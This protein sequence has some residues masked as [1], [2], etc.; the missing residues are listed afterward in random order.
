[1]KSLSLIAIPLMLAGAAAVPDTVVIDS[2]TQ[3]ALRLALDDERKSEAIY[4]AVLEVH[5]G[6][7]P[8]D[9]VVQAERRHQQW[10]LD[11]FDRYEL[12]IP[13]NRWAAQP[14]QA[15]E[16]LLAACQQ[17]VTAEID[18][19]ALYDR[20]FEFVKEP[21]I[22]QV[23]T[24]LRDASQERHLRAFNRCVDRGGVMGMGMGHGKGRGMGRG[25]GP[26]GGSG[27]GGGGCCGGCGACG[28][29]GPGAESPGR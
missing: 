16:T 4:Q 10:L 19:V 27:C 26:G 17:A 12:E 11:L 22:R 2:Q 1:M 13:E 7:L 5:P 15:P 6:A 29:P 14:P 24:T 23:F 18:N 3:E 8:F 20:F 28:G 25:M 9:H 21:E